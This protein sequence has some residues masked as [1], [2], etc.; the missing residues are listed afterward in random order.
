MAVLRCTQSFAYTDLT[1][2][3][4]R[5]IPAGNLVDD[6]D[7]AVKGRESFFEPVEASVDRATFRGRGRRATKKAAT[8][9][10][11]A[12]VE[13]VAESTVDGVDVEGV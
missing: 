13:A 2:G 4:P 11:V 6:K 8:K 7:A 10:A 5:V 9:K 3:I 12:S 1:L